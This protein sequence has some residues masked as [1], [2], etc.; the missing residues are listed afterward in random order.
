M[1][2]TSQQ[3]LARF[4][5][6]RELI[7][8][9]NDGAKVG[10][11]IA[12]LDGVI[13]RLMAH[14]EKQ[15]QHHREMRSL[16]ATLNQRASHI[17]T[18]LMVPVE[19]AARSLYPKGDEVGASIRR[20]VRTPSSRTGYEQIALAARGLAAAVEPR[21][22]EFVEAGLP[23]DFIAK[24]R[25]AATALEQAVNERAAALQRRLAATQG[26]KVEVRR[27]SAVVK[28]LHSLMKPQLRT[29]A[30]RA[31]EWNRALML[32][33]RATGGEPV[34]ITPASSA[35]EVVTARAA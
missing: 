30:P 3:Q 1:R 21:A 16:T 9:T 2:T 26:I 34:V 28:F 4:R 29:D 13:Q 27:G 15:E 11:P 14:G 18:D 22:Q 23:P 24:L 5:R 7:D 33:R 17:R 10:A 6:I 8:L 12:E 32:P 20:A 35:P 31:A 19:L 25:D